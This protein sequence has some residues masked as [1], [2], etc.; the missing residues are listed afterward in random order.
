M[1][2]SMK[3]RTAYLR[4]RLRDL[5]HRLYNL[6]VTESLYRK[7]TSEEQRERKVILSRRR[8]II[9]TIRLIYEAHNTRIAT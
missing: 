4:R 3:P 2:D 5:N 7:L 6:W 9:R 8:S 1:W